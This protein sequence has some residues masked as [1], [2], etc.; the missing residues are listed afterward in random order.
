MPKMEQYSVD[1]L[2]LLQIKRIDKRDPNAK[3]NMFK[4]DVYQLAQS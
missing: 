2:R 4:S 3:I 1:L